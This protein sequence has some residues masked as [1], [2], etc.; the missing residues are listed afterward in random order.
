M[1]D[2]CWICEGWSEFRFELRIPSKIGAE[3]NLHFDFD[4]FAPDL[5]PSTNAGVYSIYKMVPPGTHYYFMSVN[6]EDYHLNGALSVSIN[7]ALTKLINEKLESNSAFTLKM[8]KIF[9]LT[10]LNYVE[11]EFQKDPLRQHLA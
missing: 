2:N 5:M 3:V 8:K 10:K 11:S 9:T 4:E 6:G 7:E 1:K